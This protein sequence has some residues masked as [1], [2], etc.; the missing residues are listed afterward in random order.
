VAASVHGS[1]EAPAIPFLHGLTQSRDTWDE[2]A[3]HL[4]N[5]YCVWTLDFRGHGHSDRAPKYDLSGSVSD[6]ETALAAIE[7]PAIVVGH[8]LGA[9]VAE[10]LGQSNSKVRAIFLED[11]A[12]YLGQPEEWQKSVFPTL[13]SIL[14]LRLTKWLK[15]PAPLS[16]YL[17]F[18]ANG[19]IPLGGIA[20]DH[21]TERH[22]LSHAS[23]IQRLDPA[24]VSNEALENSL[25][26]STERPFA[27]PTKIVRGEKRFGAAFWEEH[28]RMMSATNPRVEIIEYKECGHHPH[29]MIAF[30]ERFLHDLEDF[31]GK[32][33]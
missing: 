9:C 21:I 23:A 4:Q 29:R 31:I 30:E 22:L 18:L 11:P 7:R 13:F 10:V 20:K 6:A 27:C 25:T 26:I 16:T 17:D 1:M 2:I 33:H 12:W 3:Q 8:S 5:Q 32:Q 28:M 15:E 24:C 19:P 14:S